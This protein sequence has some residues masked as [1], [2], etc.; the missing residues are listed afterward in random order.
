M[1]IA[2]IG[3]SACSR[4]EARLA[5]SV[6]E[7][8]A[9]R[10]ATI[11]CGGLGGVMEA[12]CRGAKSKGGL[13]VGILPGQDSSTANPWVD[14]PVV[15]GI[16][17][18]RNVAVVKSAQAVIAVCGSYGTLSEIAYA[19]K[20]GIPVV[21]LNTWSLSRNG[22]ED[23]SIVRAQSAAEA[24]DKAISLAKRRKNHGIASLRSQ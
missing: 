13:T 23:D 21:G 4:Q 5:E 16:S 8:L 20:S 18:A 15:T 12:A 24:V 1:I 9:Q 22:R 10:G 3:D 14:I 19:L 17:E 7:L 6:G 2:V 11:V